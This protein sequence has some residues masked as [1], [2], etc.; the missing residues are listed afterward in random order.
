MKVLTLGSEIGAN[1]N[2]TAVETTVTPFGPR[3]QAVVVISPD[4]LWNGTI[5]VE[6]SPDNSTWTAL[7]GVTITGTMRQTRMFNA[8]LDRYVRYVCASFVAGDCDVY[9]QGDL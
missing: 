7:S 3:R 8:E 5:T 4:E 2:G 1:G 6:T 9:V